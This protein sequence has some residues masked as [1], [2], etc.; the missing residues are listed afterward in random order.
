MVA[1]PHNF[2]TKKAEAEGS[3]FFFCFVL[4]FVCVCVL[5]VC[6]SVPHAYVVSL[7]VRRGHGM[8]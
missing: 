2:H 7:E 5:F 8:P 1:Q 4:K 3:F 6:V